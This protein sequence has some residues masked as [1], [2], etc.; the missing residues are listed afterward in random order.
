MRKR[1]REREMVWMRPADIKDK[2]KLGNTKRRVKEKKR[3]TTSGVRNSLPEN[4]RRFN[5]SNGREGVAGLA[6]GSLFRQGDG[7]KH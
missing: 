3:K 4:S 7:P 1:K 2:D 6:R 5:G